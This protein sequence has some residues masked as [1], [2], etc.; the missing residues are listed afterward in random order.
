MAHQT[1]RPAAKLQATTVPPAEDARDAN[2]HEERRIDEA[3]DES[4]PASDPPAI[5]GPSSKPAVK[6]ATPRKKK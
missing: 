6:K 4:F 1:P 5:Q 3:I 2:E